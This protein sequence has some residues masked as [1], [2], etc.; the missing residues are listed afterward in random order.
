MISM[1]HILPPIMVIRSRNFPVAVRAA[2]G[3]QR[4]ERIYPV[5]GEKRPAKEDPQRQWRRS[6]SRAQ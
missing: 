5:V 1:R 6:A 3:R 4:V 2:G